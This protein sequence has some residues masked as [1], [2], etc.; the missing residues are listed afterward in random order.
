M[1]Y[2]KLV[3]IDVDNLENEFIDL[4]SSS[5]EA[6]TALA[7]INKELD[8]AA[9]N[10]KFQKA[11]KATDIRNQRALK[12]EKAP[13]AQFLEDAILGDEELHSLEIDRIELKEKSATL[14]GL[15]KALDHKKDAMKSLSWVV[16]RREN[17]E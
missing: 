2:E 11:K 7:N 16:F 1:D 3:T 9:E 14:F 5:F 6:S 10:I 17:D 12:G 13:T 15:S 8:M 4:P